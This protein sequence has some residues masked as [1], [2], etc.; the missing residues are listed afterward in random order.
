MIRVLLAASFLVGMLTAGFAA[1]QAPA[2]SEP[3]KVGVL[4]DGASE[5]WTAFRDAAMKEAAAGG[6]A[7]DF[8]M[9]SPSTPDQQKLVAGEMLAAG[10]K[11][12]AISP[13]DPANQKA[14]LQEL[15]GKAPLVLLNRDVPDSGRVCFIGLDDKE[16]G[17]KMAELVAKL[18]PPG[19]KLAALVKTGDTPAEKARMAGLKEGLEAGEFIVDAVKADKGDRNLAWAGA[20]ELMTK[21]VEL[22]AYIAF[23]PYELPAILR[24]A[25]SHNVVG[26]VNLIGPI[27]TSDMQEAFLKGKIQ[28]AIR[29]D[30]AA[31]AKQTLAV[32]HGLAAKDPA[33]KLPENGVIGIAPIAETTPKQMTPQEKMD[34]LQVPRVPQE[35]PAAAP[36][37]PSFE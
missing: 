4:T 5:T 27:E 25:T 31:A 1:A 9:L 29:V 12:L 36:A 32:L 10:V 7:L 18:V 15:A 20:D 28:G 17:R 13:V 6:V 2:A 19:L 16:T 8:R 23:E 14:A 34:A 24:A 30:T 26:N 3:L 21:R 22:A 35:A 33:L 37:R 11:A